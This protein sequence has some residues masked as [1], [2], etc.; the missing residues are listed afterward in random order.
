MNIVLYTRDM[1][2]ITVIDL[3]LW[4]LEYGEQRRYVQV[5]LMDPVP[6]PPHPVGQLV[7][8][9]HLT[10][11]RVTIEFVPIHL[12]GKRSWLAMVD[13]EVLALNLKPS[14]LPG[15]RGAINQYERTARDLASTLLNVLAR[16]SGAR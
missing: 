15:Q 6:W 7:A 12:R 3:P 8:V 5:E 9:D 2:P 16:A 13:D 10:A 4:A 1:E 11:R 14:W